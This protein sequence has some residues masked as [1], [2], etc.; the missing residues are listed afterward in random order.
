MSPTFRCI[1]RGRFATLKPYSP[2]IAGV[3]SLLDWGNVL[4]YYD[5]A[6]SLEKRDKWKMIEY[7]WSNVGSLMARTF[8]EHEHEH[9]HEQRRLRN[10]GAGE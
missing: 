6:P 4:T 5:V 2:V 10:L 3:A 7:Y 1:H 9:E 8:A